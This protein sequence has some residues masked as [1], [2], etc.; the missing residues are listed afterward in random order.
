METW[1]RE[2][3]THV[4]AFFGGATI[5]MVLNK[6]RISNKKNYKVNQNNNTVLGDLVGR[7]KTVGK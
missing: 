6:I 5:T 1:L 3:L 2:L 4:L 7:D